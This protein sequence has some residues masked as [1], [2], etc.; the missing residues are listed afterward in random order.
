[1]YSATT[2]PISRSCRSTTCTGAE[3]RGCASKYER[4]QL[5]AR[6]AEDYA[7]S[8]EIDGIMWC[9][10][11]MG[12][13]NNVMRGTNPERASCFGQ[14]CQGKARRLGINVERLVK[15]ISRWRVF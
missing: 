3:V 6:A 1:M 8:Y 12:P 7:R 2:F 10:E 4:R 9:S 14:Y 15:A 13:L 11:R 5:F